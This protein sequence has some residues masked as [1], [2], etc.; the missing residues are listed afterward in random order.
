MNLALY[1]KLLLLPQ[2]YNE[3]VIE[4]ETLIYKFSQKAL[5]VPEDQ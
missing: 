5:H 1:L 3:E 4:P 2:D